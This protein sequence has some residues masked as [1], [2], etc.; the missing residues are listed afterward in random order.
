MGQSRPENLPQRFTP[1]KG[2]AKK[3]VSTFYPGGSI[4]SLAD[5]H[6]FS[7]YPHS[8][9]PNAVA[10]EDPAA[11]SQVNQAFDG[12]RFV[13]LLLSELS[14]LVRAQ[15]VATEE[16]TRAVRELQE[17]RAGFEARTADLE[18]Q[19]QHFQQ[20]GAVRLSGI[21]SQQMVMAYLNGGLPASKVI[22]GR[23]TEPPRWVS[24]HEHPIWSLQ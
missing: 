22:V 4:A 19:W 8:P 12:Q 2:Q 23:G 17:A 9:E 10:S 3:E 14:T 20:V 11:V 13:E 18:V 1:S 15:R 24:P 6:L 21:S 7:G 16:L 5:R